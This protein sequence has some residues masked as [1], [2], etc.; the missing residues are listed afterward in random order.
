M[1]DENI[2]GKKERKRKAQIL[3]VKGKKQKTGK[4]SCI[5]SDDIKVQEG[6]KCVEVDETTLTLEETRR[7]LGMILLDRMTFFIG[8]I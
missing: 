2:N 7:K 3:Q 8:K 6:Q 4:K 1:R 5:T